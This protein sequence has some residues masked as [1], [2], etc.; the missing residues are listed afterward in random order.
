MPL[1]ARYI[2]R[3]LGLT[4]FT[5]VG[6]VIVVFILTHLLP[7]NPA[8]LRAG[9]LADEALIA[10]YEAEMGLDQPLPVQDGDRGGVRRRRRSLAQWR[11]NGRRRLLLPHPRT[12]TGACG[13]GGRRDLPIAT[14]AVCRGLR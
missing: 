2:G 14:N 5:L 6:V 4:S 10:Q 8:A 9:P 1:L 12:S 7:G 3:R 11:R 13:F